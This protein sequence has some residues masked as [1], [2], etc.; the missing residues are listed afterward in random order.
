M[1][2]LN[3]RSR[4][5]LVAAAL[6]VFLLIAVPG[7]WRPYNFMPD[8][9]M[10]YL[11]IARNI[12]GGQGSTFNGVM[13]TNGY[14]PLWMI[15]CVALFKIFG[16]WPEVAVRSIVFLQQ[17]LS[18]GAVI[19]FARA[20]RDFAGKWALFGAAGFALYLFT[21]MFCSE[22][23]I[24]AFFCSWAFYLTV[25]GAD[26]C[27]TGRLVLVGAVC[28]FGVLA[29]LDSIFFL[30]GL[31]LYASWREWKNN[32]KLGRLLLLAVSAAIPV[33]LY[34]GFNFLNYGHLMPI[35]GAIK[36]TFPAF[37]WNPQ[38]ISL[39]GRIIFGCM[40]IGL[41][42][43]FW[44]RRTAGWLPL[45]VL[46]V[47]GHLF[48]LILFS[49]GFTYWSWYYVP[50]VLLAAAIFSLAAEALSRRLPPIWTGRLCALAVAGVLGTVAARGWVKAYNPNAIDYRN[51]LLIQPKI[52]EQ[53]WEREMAFFLRDKLP[54]GSRI[55]MW[56][57]PGI[58][59][60]FTD[61]VIVP[62]DGLVGNYEFSDRLLAS[63]VGNFLQQED[64]HFWVGPIVEEGQGLERDGAWKISHS[65][66][67]YEIE[68][69][70]PLYPDKSAGTFKVFD[71]DRIAD[72][73]EEV[74][75]PKTPPV[76][77]WKIR[78]DD[79]VPE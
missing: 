1:D 57:I 64:I 11:Q 17:M 58:V 44:N 53:S 27:R 63:G 9:A 32:R 69:F 74:S 51:P 76:G 47:T 2:R 35:S 21:G 50:G 4:R 46:G 24:N 33:V 13:T 25:R 62:S 40:M 36:S 31:G 78:T 45:A 55:F 54:S 77:V 56:D 20:L 3:H 7:L 49:R 67:V 75:H 8:D 5:I 68:L 18:L 12:A 14:H 70:P 39:L 41:T 48:Y 6:P 23:H 60:F 26:S 15:C 29:R 37:H 22:A 79:S 16:C 38:Q 42:A 10:F 52:A 19:F 43:P 34:F 30:G 61:H 65:N 28:G 59:A 71:K 72:L 73:R 66:G